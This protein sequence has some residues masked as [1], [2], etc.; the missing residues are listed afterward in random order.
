MVFDLLKGAIPVGLGF[1]FNL[2][3]I[4]LGFVAVAACLGHMY[5]LYFD[6]KGGKGVATALGALMPLGLDIAGVL[7]IAW[8]IAVAGTGYSSVGAIASICLAPA[9][10]YLLAPDYLFPV[11]GLAT[12][13]LVKH[14]S[15]I[16]RLMKGKESKVW[17][18][19][20]ARE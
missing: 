13:V 7:L 10:T 14:H 20:K 8:T 9:A 3:P 18:R 17:Q 5:P 2:P 11:M 19:G 4:T 12:L 16:Y 1:M 6:F 15:N